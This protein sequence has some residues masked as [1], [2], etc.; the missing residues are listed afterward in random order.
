MSR[1]PFSLV[2]TLL[3]GC[4]AHATSPTADRFRGGRVEWARLATRDDQWARHEGGDEKLLAM[5]REHSSLDI[6]PAWVPANAGKLENLCVFPFLFSNTIAPLSDNENRNLAEYLRRG[7]FLLIDACRNREVTPSTDRFLQAQLAQF[8]K[9]FPDLRVVSLEP[10]H[11]IFSVYFKMTEF[12]PW[13]KTDKFEPLRAIYAGDRMIALISL[14]G[15]HCGWDGAGRTGQTNA[16]DCVQ[17][18]TNI[19]VYAMTR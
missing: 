9:Q 12:P 5:M 16:A 11:E 14:V 15:F 7:G 13:R 4:V 19:Y 10:A 3:L 18:V 1:F 2:L 17:M 8:K 6:Q